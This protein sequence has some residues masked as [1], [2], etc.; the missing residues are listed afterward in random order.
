MLLRTAAFK[1]SHLDFGNED[2]AEVVPESL[3]PKAEMDIQRLTRYDFLRRVSER[4][5]A[6][7]AKRRARTR[8]LTTEYTRHCSLVS[9]IIKYRRRPNSSSS[10]SCMKCS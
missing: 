9:P 10:C 6:F 2:S 7:L 5:R 1:K 8:L 4:V 3:E